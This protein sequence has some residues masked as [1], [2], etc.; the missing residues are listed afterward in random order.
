MKKDWRGILEN[1][2]EKTLITYS[3]VEYSNFYN[4]FITISRSWQIP[5]FSFIKYNS[6]FY[7]TYLIDIAS[8]ETELKKVK[9]GKFYKFKSNKT[10]ISETKDLPILVL[11]NFYSFFFQKRLYLIFYVYKNKTLNSVAH[12]FLSA[13][14]LEREVGEMYGIHF[15]N[16]WDSRNL[17]LEY[18]FDEHPLLKSFPLTGYEEIRYD[19]KTR[20]IIREP[21]TIQF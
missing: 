13:S 2:F 20:W 4:N 10:F 14:W 6:I 12:W 15:R 18:S 17:L 19:H 16:Q 11:Y 7:K 21:I 9:Y 3:T 8:Y 5:F 1:V